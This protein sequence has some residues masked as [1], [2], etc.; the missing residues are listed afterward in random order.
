MFKRILS[1]L[2]C[3]AMLLSVAAPA[4]A[5][6]IELIEETLIVDQTRPESTIRDTTT[7]VFDIGDDFT[8][9]SDALFP[10]DP[11]DGPIIDDPCA[12]LTE[13]EDPGVACTILLPSPMLSILH[14]PPTCSLYL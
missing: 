14:L 11:D 9:P 1:G 12:D 2:L 3:I 13:P 7:Q 8:L 5:A 10:T 6:E 4:L